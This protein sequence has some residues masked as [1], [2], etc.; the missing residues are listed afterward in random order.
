MNARELQ[1]AVISDLNNLFSG[2]RYKTA[3]HTMEPIKAYAQQLPKF[4]AQEIDDFF[5]YAIVRL[6]KG[7]VEN[8]TAPHKVDIMIIVGL[9]D[10]GIVPYTGEKEIPEPG[11]KPS[12][13]GEDGWD[14]RNFGN[15]AVMEA[16]ERI[17]THYEQEPSLENGK[18]YFDGPF[19]WVMPDEDSYPYYFGVCEMSFTLSAPRKKESQFV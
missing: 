15:M 1:Q 12:F 11:E 5:P 19:H 10:D 8:Q 7:G 13:I 2:S 4:D 9:F 18:F 17:Q 3:L 6:D 16:L 14:T